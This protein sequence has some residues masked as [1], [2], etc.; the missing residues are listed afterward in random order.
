MLEVVC[1]LLGDMSTN[2]NQSQI[3]VNLEAPVKIDAPVRI[4]APVK[5]E[6]LVRIEAPVQSYY[7]EAL[8]QKKRYEH[9]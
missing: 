3:S 2:R 9:K 6:T 4:D 1:A 8:A 7:G 5:E